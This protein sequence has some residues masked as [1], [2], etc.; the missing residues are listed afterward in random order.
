MKTSSTSSRKV[1]EDEIELLVA[2][3]R[4][5]PKEREVTDS[6]VSRGSLSSLGARDAQRARLCWLL[7]MP[8]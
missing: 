3:Y 5:E 1:L 2:G 6:L 8:D 7:N 4:W